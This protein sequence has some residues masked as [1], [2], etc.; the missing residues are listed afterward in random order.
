MWNVTATRQ[1]AKSLAKLPKRVAIIY[2]VLIED[3]EREGPWPLGWDVSQLKDRP[4]IRIRLNR[5]YRVLIVV[6]APDLIVVKI[7]HRKE[8]YE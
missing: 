1:A 7:A 8:I 4:E 3:L 6:V 2:R 5:E